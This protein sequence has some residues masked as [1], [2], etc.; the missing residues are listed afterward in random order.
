MNCNKCNKEIGIVN[1]EKTYQ[2]RVGYV[3]DEQFYPVMEIGY[4]CSEC[5]KE[6]V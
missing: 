4:Y 2:V 5:L 3:E 6:G 1:E